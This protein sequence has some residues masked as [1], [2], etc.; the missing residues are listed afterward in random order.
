MKLVSNC[1]KNCIKHIFAHGEESKSL[2]N[3]MDFNNFIYHYYI[4]YIIII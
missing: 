2:Q 4:I 1:K 3:I